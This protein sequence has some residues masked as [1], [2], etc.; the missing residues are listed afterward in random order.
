MK[1]ST[2]SENGVSEMIGTIL[3]ISIVVGAAA[4]VSVYIFSQPTPA[5]IPSLQASVWNDTQTF[6]IRHDGGDPLSYEDTRIIV[7]CVDETSNFHMS[8]APTQPWTNWTN[9]DVL[10]YSTHGFPL[11]TVIVVYKGG[12]SNVALKTFF[13]G[14][15][16]SKCGV[17]KDPDPVTAVFTGSPT[18]G[19]QPLGVK[20]TD[21][22]TGS[23]TSWLWT[24]G[25]GSTSSVQSPLYTYPSAGT[26]SV[27]LT[28]SNGTGTSTVTKTNYITA[29]PPLIVDFTS[30]TTTGMKPL[31]VQFTNTS[32]GPQQ[33]YLWTFSDGG[34]S[35]IPA[36][37][38]DPNPLH[39]Y[40]TQCQY[41]VTLTVT[42]VT[43]GSN[44]TTKTNYITV[45]SN[46]AW[47]NNAW[48]YRKSITIDH[49]KVTGTQTNFPVLINLA[50][51]N[52]LKSGAM[53]N[54]NDILFTSSNG[55]TKLSHQIETYTSS[56]GALVAWVNVPYVDSTTDTT[57]YMY[58]NYSSA[59][60]QQ[61]MN[62]VWDA[63]YKAVW[64][65][66][67]AGT[68]TRYDST[69][70]A[71]NANPMNYNGDEAATG[72]IDGADHLD[73]TN[74]YLIS[75][76]NIG[77]TGNAVRTISFWANLDNTARNGMIVWGA[78]TLNQ[79]YGA[80]VRNNH[81]FMWGYGQANDW[82]TNITPATASWHYNVLIHDGT[83]ARWYV[84]GAQLGT[85][86]THTYATT[87]AVVNIGREVDGTTISYMSGTIDEV[88]ISNS[89]R[90]VAWI[91]TEYNNQND[92]SSFYSVGSPEK[93]M[94]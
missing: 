93:R 84:D 89:A 81:Y 64:H 2:I 30:N 22:S 60:N 88:R 51:D 36:T 3:L 33:S 80:S 82:D 49:T 66:N 4:L 39:T 87:D 23:V 50:S 28:V 65:L 53:T 34:I 68:G 70:N 75:S 76:L 19:N 48:G 83:T 38:T 94:C 25:D 18:S 55:I 21:A 29:F 8:T 43:G 32:T 58:Y 35:T 46:P 63:S 86:F 85:G 79:E 40:L 59:S 1:R 16:T 67:E 42:N 15:D 92:P 6:S 61:N 73:G 9:G 31:P 69:S 78:N 54:G 26:Y 5:K 71:N 77:I 74:N 37:S 14:S 20:F 12:S 72:K 17:Y 57:L 47:Y 56:T 90:S 11:G 45:T 24:F 62:G 41:N 91:T 27:S 44:A 52:D 7:N 13:V 10:Q